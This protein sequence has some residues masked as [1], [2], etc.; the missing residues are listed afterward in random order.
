M[1]VPANIE[2]YVVV[3]DGVGDEPIVGS[4]SSSLLGVGEYA[5]GYRYLIF[6]DGEANTHTVGFIERW[7][8]L[9]LP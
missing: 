8:L 9:V 7:S 3:V 1:G 6:C 2:G 5:V 4:P